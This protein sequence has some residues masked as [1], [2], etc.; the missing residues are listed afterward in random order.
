[1]LYLKIFNDVSLIRT[2]L[3]LFTVFSFLVGFISI[4]M[5]LLAEMIVRTYLNLQ[6][7]APYLVRDLINFDE[8]A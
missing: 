7:R 5:G 2:P 8:N 4:L 6:N 3:P 1:M